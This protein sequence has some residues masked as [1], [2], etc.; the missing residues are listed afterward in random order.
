MILREAQVVPLDLEGAPHRTSNTT[1]PEEG[2]STRA[3]PWSV[4]EPKPERIPTIEP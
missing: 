1:E 2:D 4:F 3:Y